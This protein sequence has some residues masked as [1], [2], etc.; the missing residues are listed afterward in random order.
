MREALRLIRDGAQADGDAMDTA[1]EQ[2]HR[3]LAAAAGEFGEVALAVATN[4]ITVR[5]EVVYKSEARDS[6]LAF[7]LFRQGLRRITFR[8]GV[9]LAE[10]GAFVRSLAQTRDV[11]ASDIDF[12]GTLWQEELEHIAYVAIDGFTEK[13][14]MS[15]ERFTTLFHGVIEDVVPGLLTLEED[16]AGDRQ[17]RQH[18]PADAFDAVERA[19]N[20]EARIATAVEASA[21][22]LTASIS[23]ALGVAALDDLARLFASICVKDPQPLTDAQ[24]GA[25]CTRLIDAYA[26]LEAWTGMATCAR[27]IWQLSSAAQGFG[28]GAV[29]RLVGLGAAVAGEPMLAAFLL[30]VPTAP[31]DAIAWMRWFLI[32]CGVLS[33]PDLLN[34]M[35]TCET[36]EATAFVKDLLHRQ[37]TA[38]LGPWAARLRDPN[39][40]VVLEVLE[41]ILQSPLAAQARPL[42]IECLQNDDGRVRAR[43]IE[44]LA[45][46]YDLAVR[47][48]IL[49]FLRDQEARVRRA[50]S[51]VMRRA[52]DRSVAPY[53]AQLVKSGLFGGCDED[54]QRLHFEALAMLGGDRFLKVFE[55]R[56]RLDGD[57]N[58]LSRLFNRG[59]VTLT[60]DPIRRS[61]LAGLAL[62][63]TPEATA[64][65][66]EVQRRGDLTLAG[67]CDVVVR[68][69]ARR[70]PADDEI[71]PI[72]AAS[73][74]DDLSASAGLLGDP[75]AVLFEPAEVLV[76]PPSRPQPDGSTP[77]AAPH[78]PTQQVAA[79]PTRPDTRPLAERPL[80]SATERFEP[81]DLRALTASPSMSEGNRFRLTSPRACIVGVPEAEPA[82][83]PAPAQPI[84]TPITEARP[85]APQ[86]TQPE[87]PAPTAARP[88]PQPAAPK[89][90]RPAP[91]PAAAHRAPDPD[92]GEAS[93]EDLL[94]GYLGQTS[95]PVR[96]APAQPPQRPTPPARPRARSIPPARPTRPVQTPPRPPAPQK[97]AA[98]KPPADVDALLKD[99]LDFDLGD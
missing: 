20:V 14:F 77:A 10:V 56:L 84:A 87:R 99:F 52:G 40:V 37:G 31:R 91:R 82:S 9:S 54:E 73:T 41:V 75:S 34:L 19:E 96:A 47:E 6:N 95:A 67:H 5:D 27:S 64:M 43:A 45:Q 69:A 12:V 53:L 72:A 58:A 59:P 25:V 63:G 42:L 92:P 28:A 78:A 44:G 39:P 55:A 66:R 16:D 29:D 23:D 17:R 88:A 98:A 48:A 3:H 8:A 32:D 76:A 1:V 51:Q 38:S 33:A 24:L 11:S 13:L 30:R 74:A 81:E 71:Q 50:V 79:T 57:G 80:L 94:R 97:A 89:P 83:A 15:E 65:I 68:L 2:A 36:P 18:R 62:L 49:P 4:R 35:K 70:D 26:E 61:A 60:D 21:V 93:V 46:S 86:R 7:D 85:P 90:A 22:A